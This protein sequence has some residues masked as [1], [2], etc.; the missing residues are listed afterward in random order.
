[1]GVQHY[2]AGI[3]LGDMATITLDVLE[4]SVELSA[5]VQGEYKVLITD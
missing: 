5:S 1:M 4:Y 2:T 3:A